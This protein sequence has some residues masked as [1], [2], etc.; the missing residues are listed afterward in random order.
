MGTE[1]MS[2]GRCSGDG[3]PQ[4]YISAMYHAFFPDV[5]GPGTGMSAKILCM[6]CPVKDECLD[7]ALRNRI[8]EGIWGGLNERERRKILKQRGGA[9]VLRGTHSLEATA[10]AV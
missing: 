10:Q 6:A 7:Y 5:G 8:K 1:W 9:Y 3:K 2:Q 4:E